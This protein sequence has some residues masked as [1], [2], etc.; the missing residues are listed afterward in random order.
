VRRKLNYAIQ[1][2]FS[3]IYHQRTDSHLEHSLKQSMMAGPFGLDSWVVALS[4]K[5]ARSMLGGKSLDFST[6]FGIVFYMYHHHH[7]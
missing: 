3:A 7:C 4:I 2:E 1:L 5:A 6:T